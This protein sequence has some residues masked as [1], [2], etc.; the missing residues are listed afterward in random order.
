LLQRIGRALQQ[1]T[2][3]VRYWQRNTTT[4]VHPEVRENL[5]INVRWKQFPTL[6]V[7]GIDIL[8]KNPTI[9]LNVIELLPY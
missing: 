3:F 7:A 4:H 8:L 5:M 9:L 6:L 1:T 2:K